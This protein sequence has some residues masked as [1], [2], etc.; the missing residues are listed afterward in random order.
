MNLELVKAL[1][2]ANGVS[3]F[4]DE[5][6]EKVREYIDKS[7][8]V[9]EDSMRNLYIRGKK[10]ESGLKVMVDGH[11]DEVGFMVQ[12]IEA[13]GLIRFIPLGGW[14]V[15][16]I[17]AHRVRVR[18]RDGNYHIGI[19]TS[20]PPHFMGASER[21]KALDMGDIYIDLGVSSYE[22][23]VKGLGIDVGAPVVPDVEFL[24]NER[25][26]IIS[27]KA[28]DN[29]LGCAAVVDLLNASIKENLNIELIGTISSQEEIGSRGGHVAANRVKP[30][31]AIVFEGTP[32]DDIYRGS[33]SSQG[34]L[35][36]GVQIRHRDSGMISSPRFTRFA[37]DIANKCNIKHQDAVRA[38]GGTNGG[39]IHISNEGVPTIVLG[40]PTRY[41]HT[42]YGYVSVED[43]RATVK[44]ALEII[45]RLDRSVIESF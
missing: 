39:R 13:N 20:K 43:Y 6:I 9:E 26:N 40:V 25:T 12:S 14:I 33:Y 18:D 2:E 3:G 4:E 19:T 42:H 31:L 36:K 32:A 21:E 27:G 30:D 28:F 22:E 1:S 15:S 38:A 35:K 45:K 34:A 10:G 7:L 23:V 41:A 5:V 37:R 16:N 29:R 17:P 11:S 8:E 24:Y 44:L